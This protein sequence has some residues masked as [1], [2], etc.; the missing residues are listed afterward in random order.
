MLASW[1]EMID[2]VATR[3]G[4]FVGRPKYSFVRC[5]VQ[6]FGTGRGDD[7]LEGFQRWLSEEPQHSTVRNYAWPYL[8]L[9]EV[10]PHGREDDLSYPSED[11]L[12]IAHL[13][14][15]LREFL[16]SKTEGDTGTDVA[17]VG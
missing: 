3:S 1:D 16:A 17:G 9:R 13:F 14:A 12:A 7:V 6:G 8:V 5:F 4:M 10:F 11:A 2:A 15:R